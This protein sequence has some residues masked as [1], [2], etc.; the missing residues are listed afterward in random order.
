MV[1]IYR[2]TIIYYIILEDNFLTWA[3]IIWLL[4]LAATNG[5]EEMPNFALVSMQNDF[6]V[7]FEVN[8]LQGKVSIGRG[9]LMKVFTI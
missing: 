2:C 3:L 5:K 7:D 9:P 8:L 6:E 1:G 4:P